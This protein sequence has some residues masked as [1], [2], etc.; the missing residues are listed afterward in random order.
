MPLSTDDQSI[1]DQRNNP[2]LGVIADST[3]Q[4]HILC[5]TI[6][7]AGY[8]VGISLSPER[9]NTE[10]IHTSTIDLWWI[11]IEDEDKWADFVALIYEEAICPVLIGDGYAPPANDPKYPR[12][13]R[14]IYTKIIDI[15]GKPAI[16]AEP[17]TLA[18]FENK[19]VDHEVLVLPPE[20]HG[21]VNAGVPAEYI[22]VIGASLGGPA[23]VKEFLDALPDGLPIAFIIA[24]HID[25]GF[26]K[27]LAQVWGRHSHF[28]FVD[29]LQGQVLSHGQVVIAPVEQ[30][31][32]IT[33]DS[34]VNLHGGDWDGPYSPSIDQV[35]N[36]TVDN[37]G[38]RTGAILFSG[39]GNDGAIAGPK[40]HELGVEVWA[41][42]ADTCA[43]SSMPD[44]ARATGCVTFSG[45]PRGL[46]EYLVEHIKSFR[47]SKR[48]EQQ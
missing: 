26:Q 17:V 7:S 39:M 24:Q 42:T 15:V 40:M 45:S 4:R 2:R 38:A 29:P 43:N 46:A 13:E 32:T 3:L 47:F 48:A 37:L 11:E 18:S 33:R 20:L 1:Q 8:E 19:S 35:M 28:S 34:T 16:Q 9:V 5:K 25:V 10:Q 23:A 41:Q 44:S 27:V 31:M 12:W 22:W 21:T 14:R 30:V 6:E 36:S